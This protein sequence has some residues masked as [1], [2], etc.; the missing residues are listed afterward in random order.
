[1]H[2]LDKAAW[3][4]IDRGE[5]QIDW[6]LWFGHPDGADYLTNEG[7]HTRQRAATD[8]TTFFGPKWLDQ[9]LRPDL[10]RGPR[11]RAS[12]S[13]PR[14]LLRLQSAELVCTSSRSAGG[15]ACSSWQRTTSRV[16]EQFVGMFAV[17]LAFTDLSIRLHRLASRRL[18]CTSVRTLR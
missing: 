7:K 2:E 14:S 13:R 3:L 6:E 4:S 15:P 10:G 17:T 12:A 1:M 16:T 8:L 5:R 18:G 9:A 11:I